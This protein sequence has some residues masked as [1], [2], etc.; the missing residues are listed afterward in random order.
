MVEA[1]HKEGIIHA[2]ITPENLLV[3]YEERYHPF[4][5]Q[6]SHHCSEEKL[7]EWQPGTIASGWSTKGLRFIDFGR[8]IDTTLIPNGMNFSTPSIVLPHMEG[9]PWTF[10]IDFYGICSVVYF[11]ITGN[12]AMEVV[13]NPSSSRWQPA[14]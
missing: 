9:K 3:L 6:F 5:L 1:L 13:Q 2:D 7:E 10:H 14:R 12:P 8:S 11:M 4:V